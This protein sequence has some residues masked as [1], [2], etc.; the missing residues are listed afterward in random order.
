MGLITT[1][2]IFILMLNRFILFF[3]IFLYLS[4]LCQI[5]NSMLFQRF[6]CFCL[7]LLAIIWS[8]YFFLLFYAML[9]LF[10]QTFLSEFF[11]PWLLLLDRLT[12][13]FIKKFCVFPSLTIFVGTSKLS[14]P[15]NMFSLFTLSS[16]SFRSIK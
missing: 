5:Y 13:L 14:A 11:L 3:S 8:Q 7:S 6:C 1:V 4:E 12:T 15:L 10:Y 16:I 9:S 2:I